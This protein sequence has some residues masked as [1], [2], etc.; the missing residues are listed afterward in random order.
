MLLIDWQCWG[1]GSAEGLQKVL[2]EKHQV[3]LFLD[4]FKLF[5]NKC[6]IRNSALLPATATLFE[7]NAVEH[8]TKTTSLNIDDAHLAICGASTVATYESTWAPAFTDIGLNNRLFLVPASAKKRFPI[9]KKL[10]EDVRRQIKTD[11]GDLLK[12]AETVPEL[13]IEPDAEELYRQWYLNQEP[14]VHDEAVRYLRVTPDDLVAVNGH[15]SAVNVGVVR[16]VIRLVDWQLEV[17]KLH[18]PIDADNKIAAME[19]KVRGLFV[20]GQS[21]KARLKAAVNYARCGIWIYRDGQEEH[22]ASR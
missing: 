6:L 22:P 11:I 13:K 3:C 14:S 21:R 9:P 1:A 7:S 16:D 4:E 20:V 17:R 5:V 10:N 19:E 2:N 15:E 8:V 12:H 18:D